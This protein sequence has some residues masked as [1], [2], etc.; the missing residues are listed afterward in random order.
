M[1]TMEPEHVLV[2]GIVVNMLVAIYARRRRRRLQAEEERVRRRRRIW[3][4]EMNQTR[5]TTGVFNRFEQLR[6][7]PDRF[8]SQFRMQPQTFQ[9]LLQVCWKYVIL[10]AM[11][12][13]GFDFETVQRKT[14][15]YVVLF[16]DWFVGCLIKTAIIW[17]SIHVSRSTWIKCQGTAIHDLSPC[18]TWHGYHVTDLWWWFGV[19]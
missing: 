8:H 7:Y 17:L 5:S 18:L 11:V 4:H 3:V 13:D 2:A 9:Y 12:L 15:V 19:G 10:S 14:I 1:L 16:V 6:Q